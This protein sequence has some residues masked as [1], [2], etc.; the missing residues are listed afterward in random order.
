[1]LDVDLSR[2]VGQEAR[3]KA[4]EVLEAVGHANKPETRT[5]MVVF[6]RA[7][8]WEFLPRERFPAADA[9][10]RLDREETDIQA[11]L[12]ASL[13]QIGEGRQGKIL[14]IS[15]GNENRG[16]ISRII[17]LLRSHGTQV[18]TLPVSLSR[19]RNEVY[20]SD[21]ASPRQVDSGEGFEVAGKIE[22]LRDAPAR[23]KLLRD[24][25]LIRDQELQ[26]RSGTNQVSFRESLFERG[27]HSYELLLES[28]DD[29]LAENNLLQ[30]VVE[31]KGAPRVLLLSG[32]NDSQQFLSKALQVQGY[33]V[34]QSAPEK[35][36]MTLTDLSS[37]DLLVLDN[38]PAFQLTDAKME[39]IEKYVR[40]LGGGLLVIGGSQ[41]YGAGGY[42]RT[43]L[44]RVL[45]VDM[46][47]PARLDLPHVALLFVLDKSG[48]MGAGQEGSTKLDLAKAAAV[49]AAD[50]M[51]PTDQVGIIG[52]DAAWDWVLPFR[53]VGNGEWISEK[54][55]GLQSDG[56]T[57]LY[58]ALVE[59][60]RAIAT[61]Q[62][63]IKHVIVLSDGLTD[64]ADFQGLG[65]R[66][67]RDGITVSTVS[68]GSDADVQLMADIAKEGKGRG[69]VAL[70]PQTIP[71]IFTAETLLISRDLLVDKLFTPSIV[72]PVGPLKGISQASVPPL[73]GY[74]L[75]YAKPRS[76]LLMSADKDPLLV[77][78]RY[79]VGRVMAFT[80]D[81]SGRW[82]KEWVTWP[83]FP[84][85]ASQ[86]ARDTM[87]KFL[88]TRMRAELQP[89]GEAVKVVAD[90]LSKE[91][92]FLNH[93]KLRS[94]IATP[95]K[96]TL[97]QALQQSA[98][99]RYETKF[100]PSQRG[101][102]LLT[103][104]AEGESGEA[105]QP[106]GTIPYIAP[107]PKEYRELKPNT[108]LLSRLAEETGGEMI[109]AD[110]LDDGIAR[111]YTPTPGK[112]RRG[113]ETWWPLAG[114]GLFYF[115]SIW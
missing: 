87:R 107:Y 82:G 55:A 10:L 80:S 6:G 94:N 41:S 67:A 72:A 1:M 101:I 60:H 97:E 108:A 51:N 86:L 56:G 114:L 112:G 9:A 31:V 19:G 57:D 68:V 92:K 43:A 90:L 36:S 13:A 73:R 110:K 95:N 89:D 39:N 28:R 78:W 25:V 88:E 74:V 38:V 103:L 75:T 23:I 106:V 2:S 14:L 91:G 64:K 21:L 111:L 109:D 44:E 22:S 45:P 35:T 15:D 85:W 83:G 26:L 12:Q 79:G 63:A 3:E 104:Y 16:E 58:K 8:E 77:S 54:L 61:K 20:L 18:W 71:Q 99:G 102:H 62:A 37:F 11:A 59:A 17:P 69:Y 33:S 27:N 50:I 7:P 53:P 65:Q 40:D 24:G 113:Q 32:N 96:T 76:E 46:R 49:A 81:L 100:I 98:P 5:G 66:M 47:P 84:Q 30:G 29:T 93:L 70:D 34:V 48:S 115:L 4:R 42:Y 105:G 52:F